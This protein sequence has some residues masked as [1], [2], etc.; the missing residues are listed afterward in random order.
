MVWFHAHTDNSRWPIHKMVCLEAP[1]YAHSL[2]FGK[3]LFKLEAPRL[4]C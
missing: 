1:K 2:C 3:L 4:A